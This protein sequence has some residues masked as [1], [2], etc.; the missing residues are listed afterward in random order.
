[1]SIASALGT[2]GTTES[3]PLSNLCSD[4]SAVIGRLSGL[5]DMVR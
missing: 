4:L 3:A 1:M 5:L 2:L